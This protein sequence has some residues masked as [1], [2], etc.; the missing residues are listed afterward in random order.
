[1]ITADYVFIGIALIFGIVGLCVGFG[2]LLGWLTSGIRGIL[3]SVFICYLIFGFVLNLGFVQTL[4]GHL[5]D[6][7]AASENGFVKFLL[8]IRIDVIALAVVLFALVQIVRKMI[9]KILEGVMEADNV[10]M[11]AINKTFGM[12][13]GFAIFLGLLLVVGQ[14]L[15]GVYGETGEIHAWLQ[16][17]FFRLDELYLKNPMTSIIKL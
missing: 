3:I 5:K 14:I 6:G 16:G 8:T 7:L 11:K 13:L 2:K 1:M 9:V 10:V 4:L 12:V 17:S 15:Y